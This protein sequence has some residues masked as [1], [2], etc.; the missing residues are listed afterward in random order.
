MQVLLPTTDM[1]P[2]TFVNSRPPGPESEA[3]AQPYGKTGAEHVP[4]E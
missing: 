3:S 1:V 4:A 2:N